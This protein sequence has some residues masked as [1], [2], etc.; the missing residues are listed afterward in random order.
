MRASWEAL[1]A[2]LS[3]SI[4]TLQ[5]DQ[6]FHE[7]QQRHPAFAGFGDPGALVAFLTSK[8]GDL[9]QKDRLLATLV[10]LVQRRDHQEL[11]SA[12]LWLGLWPGLDA[13]YRRRLKHFARRPDELVSDL[14]DAFTALVERLNLDSVTR[15]AATLVRSTERDVM[16]GRKRVW[17]EAERMRSDHAEPRVFDEFVRGSNVEA[18]AA[19]HWSEPRA[20]SVLGLLPG[21]SVDDD[22]T[23][24]RAWLEPVVGEDTE[25]LI[26]VLVLEETQREAGERLG[27]SHEAA[28]KRF[29]RAVGRVREHLASGLS[30]SAEAG[31]V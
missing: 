24:L 18:V 10:T 9:D 5:A 30:Q 1:H 25:L 3:R 7:A 13:A 31:R 28:R 12:L 14:A 20:D 6:A 23:T 4:R 29:Q 21:C 27:L 8:Q 19:D 2:S 17:A 26:A 22:V 15:V 11:A 16:D